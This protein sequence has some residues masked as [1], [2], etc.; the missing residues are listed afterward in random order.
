LQEEE[1][2]EDAGKKI[3]LSAKSLTQQHLSQFSKET[4][5]QFIVDNKAKL[6][7]T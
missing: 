6:V 7:E 4:L 5:I 1:K 2:K 3:E